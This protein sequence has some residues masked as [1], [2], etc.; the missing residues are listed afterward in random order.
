MRV[1]QLR[2]V[3][4]LE[5]FAEMRGHVTEFQLS[6]C[7]TYAGQCAHYGAQPAAI[8]KCNFAQMQDNGAAVVQQPGNVFPQRVALLPGDDA[9][10]A[11]DDGDTSHLASVE[12]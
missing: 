5:N 1:E 8:D 2:Q 7:L 11:T 9:S 4:E 10:V 3:R 12:R 6:V